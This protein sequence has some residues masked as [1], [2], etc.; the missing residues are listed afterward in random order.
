MALAPMATATRIA[1]Q[2]TPGERCRRV[3]EVTAWVWSARGV[4]RPLLCCRSF[5]GHTLTRRH[6][7]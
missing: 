4:I 6:A 2:Y 1:V 7:R 5:T 3:D